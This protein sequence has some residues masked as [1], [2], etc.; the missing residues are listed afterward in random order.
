MKTLR[1]IAAALLVV[2]LA[3]AATAEARRPTPQVAANKSSRV[4][5]L[6]DSLADEGYKLENVQEQ[7]VYYFV[8]PKAPYL[9]GTLVYTFSRN[10][11]NGTVDQ[12]ELTVQLTYTETGFAFHEISLREHLAE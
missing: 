1:H 5:S 9:W 7:P 8:P 4:Q 3:T 2:V 12:V 10:T 6:K 11:V